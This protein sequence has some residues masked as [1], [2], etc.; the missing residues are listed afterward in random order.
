MGEGYSERETARKGKE[1]RLCV[2]ERDGE[3]ARLCVREREKK[4]VR[5]QEKAGDFA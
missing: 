4:R 3:R 2:R 1:G 5:G